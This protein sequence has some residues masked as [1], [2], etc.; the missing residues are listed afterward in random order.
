MKNLILLASLG[1][2]GLLSA[3][4]YSYSNPQRSSGYYQDDRG[5]SY[6]GQVYY[7]DDRGQPYYQGQGYY[8][9]D[10][11]Q[12]YYQDR[13]GYR[14]GYQNRDSGYYQGSATKVISDQ[15]INDKIRDAIGSGWFSKGYENVSFNVRNGNV[16]LRGSVA[17][18]DDRKNVEDAVRKIEGVR[19]VDNQI[20]INKVEA[21]KDSSSNTNRGA[22]SDTNKNGYSEEQLL[23]SEK[24]YP[25]DKAAT[26][27]DRQLNAKIRDKV[28]N[29][30]F[31]QGYKTIAL[32]TN[33]GVVL[34]TGS[35]DNR[36][37][38]QKLIDK[39][40]EIEGI[41]SVDNQ[42]VIIK[43]DENRDS[44]PEANKDAYSD[45]TKNGYSDEQLLA[46][47][48]KYPQDT[49][50]TRYDRQLNAKIRDKVS[51]G[52]FTQSYTTIILRTN[53]GIV[54]ITG[55]VDSREDVKKL[56]DKIKEIDGIRT[57]NSQL[58]VRN[59]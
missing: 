14:D 51:N 25:Q 38:L 53:N 54:T 31:S 15:E 42:I 44:S 27:F 50:A 43:V 12:S 22:Y 49:A 46:S 55:E 58:S 4:Q 10:R 37:D 8:Q 20:V 56:I 16:S 47:E 41:R 26:I 18:L 7:Q 23:D 1:A 28:S 36:D 30:W 32:R 52:W 45:K 48:K 3:D 40:R 17:T 6:Q 35:L 57:V 24:K 59:A 5:Q 39:I 29:G 13:Q 34:I 21:N 2:V 33:N 19:S 11:G 9:G